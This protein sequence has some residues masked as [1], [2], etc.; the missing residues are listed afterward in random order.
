MAALSFEPEENTFNLAQPLIIL[1]RRI[2]VVLGVTM[3]LS[4]ITV[5]LS[6]WSA[7]RKPP[8]Y[9]GSFQLLVEPVTAEDQFKRL[10]LDPQQKPGETLQTAPTGLDYPTQIQILQSPKILL[11]VVQKLQ[12][13]YP[14][15]TYDR[16]IGNLTIGRVQP[17]NASK[18]AEGTKLLGVDYQ[19]SDPGLTEAVVK[20][21]AST[22]LKYSLQE[23]QTNIGQGIK[24]I[25]NQLPQLRQR[26]NTLQRQLQ[27]FRQR[28]NIINPDLQGTQAAGQSTNLEQQQFETAANLAEKAT[29]FSTL[30]RQSARSNSVTVLA[31]SPQYQA[32]LS[33]YQDIQSQIALEA[34]RSR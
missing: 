8:R 6:I 2:R 26:V 18:D 24:F 17:K 4:L 20:E 16:L 11:P 28:Y 7:N 19:D 30:Q 9:E 14:L 15:L 33:K 3:L 1:R 27:D 13:Q 21:L 5:P 34:A 10:T 25:D 31:E 23:R 32:L 12:T 22:Y 29:R